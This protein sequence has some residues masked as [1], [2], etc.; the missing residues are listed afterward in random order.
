MPVPTT[1]NTDQTVDRIDQ[2]IGDKIR[3]YVRAHYQ[4]E[5]VF[6]GN[7][8]PVNG[9]TTPV[10]TTNY[11]VGYTHTL[12]PNLVNDFRV[13][14]HFFNTATL[15]S[16]SVNG[17]QDAGT[18]LGIPG[19][20]GDSAYNNPGIPDFN[21]TGFNGLAQRAAPTGTRTTAPTSSPNR[22]V[23]RTARTTSWPGAE[24]RRLA[25]G[26]AAVNSAARHVHL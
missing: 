22:S 9:S 3:L 25:T 17:R 21:V 14:R 11:T 13:G 6:G 15:N 4:N 16:F 5:N 26:R 19:F 8:I 23:G 12:T 7:A 20:N 24:F 10:T 18:N 2:N 1:I